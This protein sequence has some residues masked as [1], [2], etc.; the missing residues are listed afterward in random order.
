MKRPY[1]PH[2][3][4]SRKLLKLEHTVDDW[5]YFDPEC[6]QYLTKN[7]VLLGPSVRKASNTIGRNLRAIKLGK[8]PLW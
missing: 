4:L 5:V 2:A 8:P 3:S 1:W 6:E 7:G